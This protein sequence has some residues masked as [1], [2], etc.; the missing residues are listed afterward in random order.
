MQ[1]VS[2]DVGTIIMAYGR[3]KNGE[4]IN[5]DGVVDVS[6]LLMLLSAYGGSPPEIW[7]DING[8]GVVDVNDLLILLAAYGQEG[9]PTISQDH[10]NVESL[11]SPP[12][13]STWHDGAGMLVT[14]QLSLTI[15][16]GNTIHTI[17]G[18]VN[19]PMILPAA[20]QEAAPFGANIGGVDSAFHSVMASS[21]FDS[22]L[23]VGITGGDG[24]GLLGAVGIDFDTWTDTAALTVNNG[25][26][27]LMNPNT[28]PSGKVVIAQITV[29][30]G[31]EWEFRCGVQGRLKNGDG[32]WI[33]ENVKWSS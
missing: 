31:S 8:D 10:P 7:D 13:D 28:G 14:Y 2:V 33:M 32:D 20:Y 25:A 24:A 1:P 27:F 30:A 23:T 26:V 5:G 17:F 16:D 21:E 3:I 11:V 6:D 18:S 9:Q 29:A 19:S 15:P 4:D 22:W 12:D